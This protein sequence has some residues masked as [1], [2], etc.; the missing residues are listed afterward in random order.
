MRTLV[1]MHALI[2]HKD[3]YLVLQRAD[4]RSNPRYWNCV[5]GHIKEHESAE[6]S[7]L[8][9]VKEETNLDGEIVKTAEPLIHFTKDQRWVI[10]A[11][12]INVNDISNLK[13]DTNESQAY[14]WIKIDDDMVKEYKGLEE[15]I[16]ILNPNSHPLFIHPF[17]YPLTPC[18]TKS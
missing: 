15:T 8:R 11:Y 14:K 12:L 16:K 6:E 4:N 3:K 10:L 1:T 7:A 13:I 2:V 5:T 18:M 9:E 17:I